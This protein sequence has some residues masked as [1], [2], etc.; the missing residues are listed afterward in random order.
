MYLWMKP[1]AGQLGYITLVTAIDERSD[2]IEAQLFQTL[3]DK[4][5]GQWEQAWFDDH[6]DPKRRQ[7]N[8]VSKNDEWH[9]Y[10]TP[11]TNK[12]SNQY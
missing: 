5:V 2:L 4:R 1:R 7:P 10:R 8:A 11:V 9:E 12:H 3:S 6:D